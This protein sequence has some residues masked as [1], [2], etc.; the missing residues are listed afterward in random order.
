L[1]TDAWEGIETFLTPDRE[2]L[3]AGDTD[4]VVQH[5]VALK[6]A[7]AKHIGQ[8][9]QKRVLAEHTYQHRALQLQRLFDD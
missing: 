5:L 3:V 2:V 4:E 9:A 7:Q 6:D 1:I 8:S